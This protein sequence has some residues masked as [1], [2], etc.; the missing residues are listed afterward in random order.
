MLVE[1]AGDVADRVLAIEEVVA[2][3]FDRPSEDNVVNT[4]RV[5]GLC[6]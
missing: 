1:Q 3:I 6:T 5:I 2:S 4:G